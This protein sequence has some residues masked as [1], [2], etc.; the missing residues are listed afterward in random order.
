[1][2][3]DE[4]RSMLRR[5]GFTQVAFAKFVDVTPRAVTNWMNGSR[6][7]PGPVTTLLRLTRATGYNARTAGKALEVYG[8]EHTAAGN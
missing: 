4:L 7:I 1:M 8:R 6:S 2:T 3:P 5:L